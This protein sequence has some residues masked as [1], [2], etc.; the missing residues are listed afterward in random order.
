[1]FREKRLMLFHKPVIRMLFQ[2]N[3]YCR[4]LILEGIHLFFGIRADAHIEGHPDFTGFRT[5][6]P[7]FGF[8]DLGMIAVLVRN[9]SVSNHRLVLLFVVSSLL[10]M[11]LL[12]LDA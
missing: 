1:M 7:Y 2:D 8:N 12:S 9:C 4:F 11:L 6:A 5:A 3:I 10:S